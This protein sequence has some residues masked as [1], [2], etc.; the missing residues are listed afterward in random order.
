[1]S[2][3][4]LYYLIFLLIAVSLYYSVFRKHQQKFLCIISVFF[5]FHFPVCNLTILA[6]S[7]LVNYFLSQ[8]IFQKTHLLFIGIIFNLLV[9]FLFKNSAET[10][11]EQY[12]WTN[13]ILFLYLPENAN[14]ILFTVGISFYSL[15]NISYLIDIYRKE[16]SAEKNFL[17]Y[18]FSIIF[19]PKYMQGPIEKPHSLINQFH[20]NK[21]FNADEILSALVR[22]A[23]G[24]AKKLIVA[25]R[26]TA[27]VHL[28]A[29]TDE[30]YGFTTLLTL[31]LY[32]LSMY[33]DFSG[34]MDI[35]LG[36]AKL[37]GFQLSENFN[38]PFAARSITEFWRRWHI[39]LMNFL[40]KYIYFPIS[41]FFR[42]QKTFGFSIA[43]FITF[44]C[45]AL[46]H[47]LSLT[48]FV[49]GCLHASFIVI[50][51]IIKKITNYIPKK[52]GTNYKSNIKHLFSIILTFH[53]FCF[54]NIFFK[55]S[56]LEIAFNT[57]NSL[58]D[59]L[60]FFPNN[61]LMDSVALLSGGG[62]VDK[63]FNFF[64]YLV[65][66]FFFLCSEKMI[67]NNSK[68]WFKLIGLIILILLFGA[69]NHHTNF[70]YIVY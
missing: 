10:V 51:L 56:S 44:I 17:S 60:N 30:T 15:Q 65:L 27:A 50:E 22:I 8:I 47:G 38:N 66:T 24:F 19:F 46:W 61:I 62:D 39:T 11:A 12:S 68:Y 9:L 35:A 36:S 20:S 29:I 70:I 32:S 18:T 25:D 13:H 45:S 67:L 49:W 54:A 48:Y 41:Y 4:S 14:S 26:L 37:F 43:I 23:W 52:S 31:Y 6:V 57:V 28:V 21:N 5:L 34:Y 40:N 58:F 53:L 16:I 55:S 2:F 33:F 1:M 63:F 3:A 42:K 59:F 69:L 64:S 7:L